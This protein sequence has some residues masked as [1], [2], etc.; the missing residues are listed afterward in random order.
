MIRIVQL[1]GKYYGI[2]LSNDKE[3]EMDEIIQ[4]ASEGNP[5]IIVDDL[6]TLKDIGIFDDVQMVDRND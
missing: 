6:E 2:E 3:K 4:F 1:S 5:V